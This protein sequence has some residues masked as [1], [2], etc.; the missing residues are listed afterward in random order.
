MADLS[1][2]IT[3]NDGLVAGD[4]F[5]I[6]R[7]VTDLPESRTVTKAWLTIKDSPS[8]PDDQAEVQK[9]ITSSDVA[10]EG[11]ISDTGSGTGADRKAVMLFR[12]Q[13]ADTEKL[14]TT[15]HFDVQVKLDDGKVN[16]PFVGKISAAHDVTTTTS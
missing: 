3:D 14:T 1:Q 16:T 5:D 12:L 4:D 13:P 6:E 15:K 11:V 8:D 9:T 10:D 2:Q 7:T